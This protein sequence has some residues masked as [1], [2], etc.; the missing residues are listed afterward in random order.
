VH[1]MVSW[2]SLAR[3]DAAALPP[4]PVN[5]NGS[6]IPNLPGEAGPIWQLGA[7]FHRDLQVPF[8]EETDHRANLVRLASLLPGA[9]EAVAGQFAS[10]QVQSWS[11]VRA[12]TA[13]HLPLAGP[14]DAQALPGL[15]VSTGMGS[16]GLSFSVLCAELIAAQLFA[17]PFPLEARLAAA[18]SA[19]RRKPGRM[20]G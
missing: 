2:G 16:R 4:F 8:D 15:W 17:E 9:A 5:G 3:I 19:S 7:S 10:R 20:A 6:F 12:T 11:G 18:L 13:D 14:V 1:G